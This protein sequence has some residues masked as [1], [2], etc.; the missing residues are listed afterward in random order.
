MRILHLSDRLSDRGGAHW[1]LLGLLR[2]L[3]KRGHQV[4]LAVGEDL[5]QLEQPCPTAVVPGLEARTE[6]AVELEPVLAELLPDLVH[7][8]TVVNPW[9]LRWAAAHPSL[10]TVQDHRYFCPGRGKWH[11]ENRVCRQV[12][13]PASC[14]ACFEDQ[15]YAAEIYRLTAARLDALKR[16]QVVTLSHYM[17]GELLAAGL[18][19][20]RV[21]VI[22]PFVHGLDPTIPAEGVPCVLFVGRLVAH[23]GVAQALEARRLSGLAQPI[24][25][26][27]SGPLR[28]EVEA[29]GGVAV[30]WVDHRRLSALLRGATALLMPSRW[31]EP[32]GIAG[33]EALSVGTPVVAW[34]SGGVREWHPG[35]DS[36]QP[37]GDVEGLARALRRVQ[38]REVE[39]PCGFEPEALMDR[40]LDVYVRVA[41]RPREP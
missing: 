3:R 31:Q 17:E 40:L 24:V 39:A 37:W 10:I 29:G 1:H 12:M 22:P 33:L 35:D 16:I 28:S 34:D 8:H 27:G 30:G 7:V 9:V 20:K 5:G 26:A 38:G 15:D 32:F 25:F 11:R 4:S 6:V 2:A 36:L 23:K 21:Q 18:E 41:G 14:A 13:S 19:E